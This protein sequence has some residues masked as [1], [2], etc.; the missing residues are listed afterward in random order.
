MCNCHSPAA[1]QT[2]T[3][4]GSPEEEEPG[5]RPAGPDPGCLHFLS[6]TGHPAEAPGSTNSL[7][8]QRCRRRP[9]PLSKQ[10]SSANRPVTRNPLD[11]AQTA[12]LP[13]TLESN[14]ND[15][16]KNP[17]LQQPG[18]YPHMTDFGEAAV[19]RR[20]SASGQGLWGPSPGCLVQTLSLKFPFNCRL[21]SILFCIGFTC[22]E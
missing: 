22:M 14:D 11:F 5:R 12:N 7:H 16:K 4:Q 1:R 15:Q 6:V 21:H 8:R 17:T 10:L 9:S 19:G 3:S 18:F 13:V 2:E 20:Q